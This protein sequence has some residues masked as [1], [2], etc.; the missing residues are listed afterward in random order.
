[1]RRG[2]RG[3]PGRAAK[4]NRVRPAASVRAP[5]ADA[6]HCNA[7]GRGRS[8]A[9][10]RRRP[11]AGARSALSA[12]RCMRLCRPFS[13]RETGRMKCCS[14]LSLSSRRKP[15]QA[16]GALR[17]EPRA[18]VAADRLRQ[19][20]SFES[21]GEHGLH[22]V[23]RLH[24]NARLDEK[25]RVAV[26]DRQQIDALLVPAAKPA[27]EIGGPLFFG[28]LNRPRSPGQAGRAANADAE[29]SR[30]DP[31]GPKC[32]RSLRPPATPPRLSGA[33]KSAKACGAPNAE[34]QRRA[35]MIASSLSK[36]VR[37]GHVSGACERSLNQSG[38]PHARRT[39]QTQKVSRL[40]K[41]CSINIEIRSSM[42]QVSRNGV[43]SSPSDPASPVS[44]HYSAACCIP[45][46]I[47]LALPF[48]TIYGK[49]S[50]APL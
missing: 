6:P 9:A 24:R 40:P 33:P 35:A 18:V 2:D 36:G 22:A 10:A 34:N 5:H 41:S 31:P 29:P 17:A 19:A 8:P 32:R 26:G 37:C 12:K 1:M 25:P 23:D 43:G 45:V 28:R 39:R 48:C 30:P 16:A 46:G 7:G 11:R 20:V 38:S 47:L 27:L 3:R 50:S 15:R 49:N 13:R 42:A 4:A 44:H 21:G 14:T